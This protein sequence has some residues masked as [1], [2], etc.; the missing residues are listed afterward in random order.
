MFLK[1]PHVYHCKAWRRF[2]ADCSAAHL[3]VMLAIKLEVVPFQK[4]SNSLIRLRLVG[5]T[6]PLLQ[7]SRARILALRPS[8]FG[9][10]VYKEV[11]SIVTSIVPSGRSVYLLICLL[12]SF[13][14]CTNDLT[15]LLK[16][17]R[18]WS[19]NCDIFSVGQP[20]QA[21]TGLPGGGLVCL[22][23]FGNR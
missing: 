6:S 15:L 19:T 12:K 7:V 18:K 16:G 1:L 21:T 17:L 8:R 14:S 2:R 10:L 3:Q 9:M 23:I 13:V 4:S 5:F 11:T 22:C 20:I